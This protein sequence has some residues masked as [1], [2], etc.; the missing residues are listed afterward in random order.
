MRRCRGE[1]G[2][3]EE[4][5]GQR[6]V[7]QW[8]GSEEGRGEEEESWRKKQGKGGGGR[9]DWLTLCRRHVML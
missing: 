1:G 6:R 8:G 9:R 5:E 4:K 2:V 3:K 7:G